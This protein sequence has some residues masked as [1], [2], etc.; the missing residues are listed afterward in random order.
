[1]WTNDETP[2]DFSNISWYYLADCGRRHR[3]E[4]NCCK[5]FKIFM[6]TLGEMFWLD[7]HHI[8][9]IMGTDALNSNK[10]QIHRMIQHTVPLSP[11]TPEFKTVTNYVITEGLLNQS[12]VSISRIQNI[13]LWEMFC[14]KKKQLMRI[15]GMGMAQERRLFHGTDVRNIDS[16]CKYNFD[17]RLAG[18]HGKAYVNGDLGIAASWTHGA[19]AKTIILARVIVGKPTLGHCHLERPDGGDLENSHDCCV[20]NITHPNICHI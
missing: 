13:D 10:S 1:M 15:K 20:D 8:K 11:F 16:I 12:I 4:V 6:Y 7:A 3:F 2:M 5:I 9:W 17:L 14:R 18:K 19:N